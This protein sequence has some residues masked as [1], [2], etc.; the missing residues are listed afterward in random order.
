MRISFK[1]LQFC[2]LKKN[3]FSPSKNESHTNL[4]SLGL[5]LKTNP[6]KKSKKKWPPISCQGERVRTNIAQDLDG[7]ETP[8]ANNWHCLQQ[9]IK[10]NQS[11]F[12][13]VWKVHHLEVCLLFPQDFYFNSTKK[14][15]SWENGWMHNFFRETA[16]LKN[17]LYFLNENLAKE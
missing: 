15:H 17:C 14:K 8:L 11:V 2:S 13:F 5:A 16:H 10:A 9:K 6:T 4:K 3:Q 1:V 12:I 7:A